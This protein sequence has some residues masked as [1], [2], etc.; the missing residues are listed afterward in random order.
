VITN[1][2]PQTKIYVKG[3]IFVKKSLALTISVVALATVLLVGTG[4]VAF[5]AS[6]SKT[7]TPANA[8]VASNSG[9]DLETKSEH[10]GRA[11]VA[12]SEAREKGEKGHGFKKDGSHVDMNVIKIAADVL[13]QTA[14]DVKEA[15]KTGK[16]S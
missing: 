8:A 7:D 13:G 4:M 6:E 12:D 2:Q 5:A 9:S 14:D 16:V 1:R 15:I 10:R 11:F 3:G